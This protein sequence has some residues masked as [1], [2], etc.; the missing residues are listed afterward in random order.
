ML[1]LLMITEFNGKMVES[2]HEKRKVWFSG[3]DELE[4]HRKYLQYKLSKERI[5]D[6]NPKEDESIKIFFMYRIHP[7]TEIHDNRQKSVQ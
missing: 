1:E 3:H 4:R 7:K 6:W 5:P 2:P